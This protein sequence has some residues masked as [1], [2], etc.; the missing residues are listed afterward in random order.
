MK[1]TTKVK[2]LLVKLEDTFTPRNLTSGKPSP[3]RAEIW[4]EENGFDKIYKKFRTSKI[5]STILSKINIEE[6]GSYFNLQGYGFG[7]WTSQG[8]RYNY[9]AATAVCLEDLNRVL[10]FGNNIG[11]NNHVALTF[12]ARGRGSMRKGDSP[13]AHYEP[14]TGIINLTRYKSRD[15]YLSRR[16]TPKS[17]EYRFLHTGGVGALCHELGHAIDFYGG[18]YL[19][20]DSKVFSLSNGRKP[21]IGRNIYKGQNNELRSLLEDVLA[22]ACLNEQED[23]FSPYYKRIDRHRKIAES[24]RKY[25]LSRTELVARLFEQY[26]SYKLKELGV[27]NSLLTQRNYKDFYYPTSKEFQR[28][29]KPFEKFIIEFRKR[30]AGSTGSPLKPR[31][32]KSTKTPTKPKAKPKT[33]K[34]STKP[35]GELA[36]KPTTAKRKNQPTKPS[37]KPVAKPKNTTTTRKKNTSKPQPASQSKPAASTKT[38]TVKIPVTLQTIENHLWGKQLEK[39]SVLSKMPDKDFLFVWKYVLAG[40]AMLKKGLNPTDLFNANKHILPQV[41]HDGIVEQV[42]KEFKRR[43]WDNKYSLFVESKEQVN[44]SAT[45]TSATTKKSTKNTKPINKVVQYED[46]K[47]VHNVDIQRIQII[48]KKKPLVKVRNI[49]K[50]KGQKFWWVSTNQAWQRKLDAEGLKALEKVLKEMRQAKASTKVKKKPVAKPNTTKKAVAKPKAPKATS[51][52]GLTQISIKLPVPTLTLV[53]DLHGKSFEEVAVIRKMSDQEFLLVWQH[54]LT[55]REMVTKWLYPLQITA[56]EQKYL[57]LIGNDKREHIVQTEFL[58]RRLEDKYQLLFEVQLDEILTPAQQKEEQRAMAE[59]QSLEELASRAWYGVSTKHTQRGKEWIDYH[60]ER[61]VV[62]I[63]KFRRSEQTID[64]EKYIQQYVKYG[65]EELAAYSNT[66]SSFVTGPSNFPVKKA[67]KANERLDT[68]QRAFADWRNKMLEFSEKVPSTAIRGGTSDTIDQL[69]EKLE[70]HQAKQ[71]EMKLVNSILRSKEVK[72]KSLREKK[73]LLIEKGIAKEIISLVK[74]EPWD[75][76]H[77]IPSYNLTNN[78]GV[79][80]NV[81]KRIEKEKKYQENYKDGNKTTVYEDIGLEVVENVEETRLQLFFE[82]KPVDEIIE[83]L[84]SQGFNWAPTKEAWQRQLT[85]NALS[86]LRGILMNI[87]ELKKKVVTQ[88]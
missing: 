21:Y 76:Y 61:L 27:S 32:E 34:K 87:R 5:E 8:D 72:I 6:V 52:T 63:R 73:A 49:L 28:I 9:L 36:P 48:F 44:D 41:A 39:T 58:R 1:A 40:N 85:P 45:K 64:I 12:G 23:D 26:V 71:E 66:M 57:N 54:V 38:I 88:D 79:I 75:D 10:K 74:K 16:E 86:A 33:T 69:L 14:A 80:R 24:Y 50:K 37:A 82:D 68:K 3:S 67:Q 70:K 30:L 42:N 60:K 2:P 62:D 7:K 81:K 53:K 25:L 29:V 13:R 31:V 55:A 17:H 43:G 65:R 18:A 4:W 47:V 83:L 77:K 20:T 22:A 46:F 84:K 19:D 59:L 51:K 35:K 15:Y 56:K 11:L 78:N